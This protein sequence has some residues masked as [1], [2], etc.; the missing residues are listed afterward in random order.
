MHILHQ[1]HIQCKHWIYHLGNPTVFEK[2]HAIVVQKLYTSPLKEQRMTEQES[3]REKGPCG[4][5]RRRDM[6][7]LAADSSTLQAANDLLNVS[8]R[9]LGWLLM[10]TDLSEGMGNTYY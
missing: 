6:T 5:V 7:N 10:V 3:F 1:P 4:M 8:W 9:T 2:G